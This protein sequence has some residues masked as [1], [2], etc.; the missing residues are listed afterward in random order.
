MKL[1]I[2]GGQNTNIPSKADQKL[3]IQS[4]QSEL[5]DRQSPESGPKFSADPLSTVLF[6][7]AN[8]LYLSL[9]SAIRALF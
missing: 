5:L 6:K 7:S 2:I 9:K 3:M 4:A 1:E 8:P